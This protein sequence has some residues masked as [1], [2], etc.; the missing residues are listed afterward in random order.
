MRRF[1]LIG[2][3]GL[4]A[5]AVLIAWFLRDANRFKPAL[6][7]YIERQTGAEVE[8]HGDLEWGFAPRLWV[9]AEDLRGSH[10]WRA[11]SLERLVLRPD[12]ASLVRNPGT[13][14]NWRIAGFDLDNLALADAPGQMRLARLTLHGIGPGEPAALTASLVYAPRG[15]SPIEVSLAGALALAG[16]RVLAQNLSFRMPSANGICNIEARRADNSTPAPQLHQPAML[17][18]AMM[19]TYDWDGR[20][21]VAQFHRAGETVEKFH[22]VFDNKEATSVVMVGAPEFLGG[23]ARIDLLVQADRPLPHWEIRPALTGVD[24]ARLAAWLG[25]NSLIAAPVDYSG[26]ITMAGNTAAALAASIEAE[27][28]ISTAAGQ[29]DGSRFAAALAEATALIDAADAEPASL[30]ALDYEHLS[31]VWRIDGEQHSLAI[32]LDS[33]GLEVEGDY[34]VAEDKLELQGLIDLGDSIERWGLDLA[35]MLAALPLHFRCGG[36]LKEPRCR[37][38]AGRLLADIAAKGVAKANSLIERHVPPRYRAAARSLF[39]LLDADRGRTENPEQ[40]TDAGASEEQRSSAGAPAKP[41]DEAT[42]EQ[43]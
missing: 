23:A 9:A 42:E 29:L 15:S 4:L 34:S 40:S 25:G 35:P 20:C 31:G 12:I 26:S 27:S 36:T 10:A 33:L 16:N 3:A 1:R 2:L 41:T 18:V 32:A 39:D 11:W 14:A 37:L 21:D 17:P 8:I 5:I 6:A 19:R 38:D 7:T 13:S 28:R 43:R 24:S 30:G 22:V